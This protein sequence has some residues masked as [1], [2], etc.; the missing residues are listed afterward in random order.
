MKLNGTASR[1]IASCASDTSSLDATEQPI[2]HPSNRVHLAL[3][4]SRIHQYPDRGH[5]CPR[6]SSNR[7][8]STPGANCFPSIRNHIRSDI[9]RTESISPYI[10]PESASFRIEDIPALEL[11]ATDE[12]PHQG[13]IA[14]HPSETTSEVTAQRLSCSPSR[15][16]MPSI[17]GKATL[18]PGRR[19][20]I[21]KKRVR[22]VCPHPSNVARFPLQSR[23]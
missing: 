6:T 18:T 4:R 1:A 14:S 2:R 13:P 23:L 20:S 22:T 17:P 19:V 8:I 7:R 5:P 10:S 9:P 12:F 21:E 11:R 3:H 15:A 16:G